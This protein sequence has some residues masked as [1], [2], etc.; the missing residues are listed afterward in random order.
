M[1]ISGRHFPLFL[2]LLACACT[3]DS[4]H[5]API[6]SKASWSDSVRLRESDSAF[7]GIP[8]GL[9]VAADGRIFVSDVAAGQVLSFDAAGNHI[10]RYGKRGRGP[11]ELLAPSVLEIRNDDELLVLDN[12]TA[13]AS[14]F[15]LRTGRSAGAVR[16]LGPTMD[17]RAGR[18]AVWMTT[19]Q[20]GPG[21]TLVLWSVADDSLR[22]GGRLP[23]SYTRFPRLLRS[24]GLGLVALSNE[25]AWVGMQGAN[26]VDRYERKDPA[27][28]RAVVDV[29]RARRRGV[30]LDDAEL[31][32]REM[33][34]EDEVASMSMLWALGALSDGRV[35]TVHLDAT[36]KDDVVLAA[37]YLSVI[38]PHSG[39]GCADLPLAIDGST[40]PVLRFVGDRLYLIESKDIGG[41]LNETWVR[42][43]DVT[44][45]GCEAGSDGD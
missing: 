19:T 36:Y 8:G 4:R 37:A 34:Y 18:D 30:P 6:A 20:A 5:V 1:S 33:S 13:R 2:A 22:A 24:T 28:P 44:K 45:L 9:T 27:S 11:G 31:M 39:S 3:G 41:M 40:V 12:P 14:R 17:L 21:T 25:D 32:Q 10:G 42:G 29:P 43:L 16:L 15:D 7:V 38:D 23:E 26:T 35:A